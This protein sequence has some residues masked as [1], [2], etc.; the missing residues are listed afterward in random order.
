MSVIFK[1][2]KKYIIYI[3]I[4]KTHLNL[5]RKVEKKNKWYILHRQV[6]ASEGKIGKIKLSVVLLYFTA[7]EKLGGWPTFRHSI[8]NIVT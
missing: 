8:F 3:F 5:K 7:P 2:L 6:R 4:L 1:Y